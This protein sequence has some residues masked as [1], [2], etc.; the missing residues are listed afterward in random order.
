MLEISNK[1]DRSCSQGLCIQVGWDRHN[2]HVFQMVV[3]AIQKMQQN[4]VVDS[5]W[6]HGG[7]WRG[8]GLLVIK[9]S[10]K[11]PFEK[12]DLSDRSEGASSYEN[13]EQREQCRG[14]EAGMGLLDS[15]NGRKRRIGIRQLQGDGQGQSVL[16]RA[17]HIREFKFILSAAV[18]HWRGSGRKATWSDVHCLKCHC[19]FHAMNGLSGHATL[20][21]APVRCF[22]SYY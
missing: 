3:S 16:S 21:M 7:G 4:S 14:S 19:A 11:K 5:D 17:R 6:E 8:G 9:W 1:Q 13:R 10:G 15:R 20:F 18:H 2:C 22:F 12:W